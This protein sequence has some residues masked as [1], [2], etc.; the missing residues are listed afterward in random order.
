MLVLTRRIG[1]EICIAGNVRIRVVQ[2]DS[3]RVYLGISAPP[4]V[5]ID[6]MEIYLRRL[7]DEAEARDEALAANS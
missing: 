1:E 5:R 3:N 4:E 2:V 6:R 7:Q